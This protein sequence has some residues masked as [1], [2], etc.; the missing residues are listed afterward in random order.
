[1]GKEKNEK[2]RKIVHSYFHLYS[3]YGI[4]NFT[5]EADN[6]SAF[7]N[8]FEKWKFIFNVNNLK[9]THNPLFWVITMF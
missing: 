8:R 5:A 3:I 6:K 9:N 4:G 7:A 1:M 2:R